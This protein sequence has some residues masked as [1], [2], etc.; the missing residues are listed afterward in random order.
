MWNR[1]KQEI[2][3]PGI[4]HSA[5]FFLQDITQVARSLQVP[6]RSTFKR[7]VLS[8]TLWQ[9]AKMST[10]LKTPKGLKDSECNKRA[11]EQSATCPVRPTNGSCNHQG[12]TGHS[13]DETSQW[14]HLQHVHPSLRE[15]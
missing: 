14:D 4:L 2:W 15:Q 11:A 1:H 6:P 7:L 8:T 3:R 12:N 5:K 13:E 9:H 10:T